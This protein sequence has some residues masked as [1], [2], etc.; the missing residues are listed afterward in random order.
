MK[1]KIHNETAYFSA[2]IDL[3][4]DIKQ[5][6]PAFI[7]YAKMEVPNLVND[8][9]SLDIKEDYL[10]ECTFN[11]AEPAQ[12]WKESIELTDYNGTLIPVDTPDVLVYLPDGVSY[13]QFPLRDNALRGNLVVYDNLE[14]YY[15]AIG[16]TNYYTRGM[17][18]VELAGLAYLVSQDDAYRNVHYLA[19]KYQIP[20][21]TSQKLLD[22]SLKQRITKAI[23]LGVK[24]NIPVQC[25]KLEYADCLYKTIHRSLGEKIA[26]ARYAVNAAN[27]L[28]KK[29]NFDTV[30]KA[31][32]SIEFED[33]EYIRIA[34]CNDKESCIMGC[35]VE[36]IA[37]KGLDK[38]A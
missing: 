6:I 23:T 8:K 14:D 1:S 16:A 10:L 30:L 21:N 4:G 27:L 36:I 38:A 18:N 7:E 17:N 12:F 9:H 35:L 32:E 26:K 33:A 11:F 34:S 13:W 20:F 19:N 29:Y 15:K 31:I 3:N 28:I 5:V 22:V 2:E 37:K 24:S 25:R